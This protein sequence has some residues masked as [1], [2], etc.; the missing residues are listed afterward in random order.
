MIRYL[1]LCMIL[2]NSGCS[3]VFKRATVKVININNI[4]S[5]VSTK[6]DIIEFNNDYY[7]KV[8]KLSERAISGAGA[9]VGNT[10]LMYDINN[11]HRVIFD[12]IQD[13]IGAQGYKIICYEDLEYLLLRSHLLEQELT[14]EFLRSVSPTNRFSQLSKIFGIPSR[15]RSR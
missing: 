7:S 14:S 3:N 10:I 12:I 13:N 6:T 8:L 2:L 9:K 15:S 4:S 1:I 5:L 11:R